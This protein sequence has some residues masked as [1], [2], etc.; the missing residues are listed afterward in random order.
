[1]LDPN[2]DLVVPLIQATQ[3]LA[4]VRDDPLRTQPHYLALAAT[5]LAQIDA[6][7]LPQDVL[8]WAHAR[9]SGAPAR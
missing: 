6:T 3:A 1:M 2:L 9:L 5:E 8:A 4:H 7:A